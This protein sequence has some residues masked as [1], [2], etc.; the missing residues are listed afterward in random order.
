MRGSAPATF[1]LTLERP[2]RIRCCGVIERKGRFEQSGFS[3]ESNGTYAGFALESPEGRLV[4]GGIRIPAMDLN[5][6]QFPTVAVLADGGRIPAGEYRLHLL[7]DGHSRLRIDVLGDRDRRLAPTRPTWTEGRL[8]PLLPPQGS[9][10]AHGREAT[11]LRAGAYAVLAT[12]AEGLAFQATYL[13]HCLVPSDSICAG[14]QDGS[15]ELYR[16][17]F[18]ACTES[19]GTLVTI[20]DRDHFGVGEMD[21]VFTTA[22]TGAT[23][24]A[25]GFVLAFRSAYR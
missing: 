21:A 12:H 17:P 16:C 20:F 9:P 18:D 22:G 15:S 14:S 10:A 4:V 7:T 19:G 5:D 11:R 2:V 1:P 24:A 23:L 6:R 3:V 8:L 25:H 13:E